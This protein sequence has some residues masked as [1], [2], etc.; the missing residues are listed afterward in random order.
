MKQFISFIAVFGILVAC[1]TQERNVDENNNA[2]SVTVGTKQLSAVSVVL[3]GKANLGSSASTDLKVG[4]Q[5]SKYP[6]ILPSNCTTVDATDADAKYNYTTCLTGLEPETTYYFRS[7]VHQNGQDTHGETMSFTTKE[8]SSLLETLDATDIEASSAK[9][10]AKLDLTDVQYKS[11]KYGF[12]WVFDESDWDYDITCAEIKN[13]TISTV[14]TNLSHESEYKYKAYLKLDHQTF[15]GE[16]KT[17]TTG[18]VPVE[19]VTLNK[20]DYTFN[21]IG[22]TI[23]LTATVLPSDA[24]N[25]EIDWSSDNEAV[26]TVDQYGKVTANGNGTATITVITKDQSKT[27]T[28]A[29]TVAQLMTGITLSS[30]SLTLIEGEEQT[31]IATVNPDNANDKSVTWNSSDESVAT[32]DASGK[33]TAISKGRATITALANDSSGVTAT[34]DVTVKPYYTTNVSL[35]NTSLSLIVGETALL[36]ATV[37]I[38]PD[39]VSDKTVTWTTSNEDVA[40]VDQDG[41]VTGVSKG[42]ATIYA[43]ANDGSGVSASCAVR[44]KNPKNPCPSGAVDLGLSVYWATRNLGADSPEDYGDYYAW[45]EIVGRYSATNF[46]WGGYKFG[47]SSSGPFSKY[48]TNSSYGPVDN[49]TVLDAEDDAAHMNLG[50]YWRIPSSDEWEELLTQCTWEENNTNKYKVIGPNGNS[51]YLPCL[52]LYKNQST[53]VVFVGW[54]GFYWSSTLNSSNPAQAKYMY[55]YVEGR[56]GSKF[57]VRSVSS[58]DRCAF[59]WIRPVAE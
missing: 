53:G 33:V 55:I 27:A 44:V 38:T 15:Y 39:K 25:K 8:I 10:N 26:A 42:A 36:T 29:I 58:R 20:E 30:T 28:C 2:P 16:V 18:V 57:D 41:I 48:N 22:N 1:S 43:T 11:V 32:V 12:R 56:Y 13:N 31:L 19:S 50:G 24:T 34:C 3:M 49:K 59:G 14:V 54:E 23:Y 51:I 17:F 5:Y 21:S 47:T 45:G 40:T 35:N 4:F 6:G 46:G 37:T 9:L 7:Y 52:G